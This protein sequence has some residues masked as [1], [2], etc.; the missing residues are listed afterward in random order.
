M[1]VHLLGVLSLDLH[2]LFKGIFFVFR[3]HPSHYVNGGISTTCCYDGNSR[4]LLNY[5]FA[6][7]LL[8][9]PCHP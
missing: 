2:I 6:F 3:I 7:Y 4:G 5:F 8:Q 1:T 9:Q